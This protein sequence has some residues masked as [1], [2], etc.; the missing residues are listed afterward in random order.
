MT[1]RAM[2]MD[3]DPH[4]QQSGRHSLSGYIYQVICDFLSLNLNQVIRCDI[5]LDTKLSAD[6]PSTDKR[7]YTKLVM[8]LV[9]QT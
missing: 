6:E 2:E 5:D 1:F 7:S 3:L 9:P 4:Y 8:L